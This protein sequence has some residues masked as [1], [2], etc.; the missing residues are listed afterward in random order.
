MRIIIIVLA[1]LVAASPM[2]L[3]TAA[4]ASSTSLILL[5]NRVRNQTP[6]CR[7]R[8]NAPVRGYVVGLAGT[9]PSRTLSFVG[10]F[11]SLAECERWR[12]PVSGVITRRIIQDRC[13]A[14]R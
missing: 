8:P 7:Q 1:A 14:Q 9:R 3:P 10:C 4:E 12:R 6:S 2:G 11:N 13:V 5:E